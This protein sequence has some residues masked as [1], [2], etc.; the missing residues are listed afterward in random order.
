MKKKFLL[1]IFF[2]LLSGCTS[3]PGGGKIGAEK[4][5]ECN[6]SLLREMDE[7]STSI[8]MAKK[9][10]GVDEANAVVFLEDGKRHVDV[11]IKASN[12]QRLRL[13]AIRKEVYDALEKR[14]KDA[15]IHVT[16]DAKV[17]REIGALQKKGPPKTKEEA[18]KQDQDL[19]KIEKD[20][21]G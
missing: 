16:T 8:A 12:F 14:Y 18:C 6:V 17:Y 11:G 3:L 15:K 1:L 10:Y 20:M 19:K 21:K 4:K 5:P 9:A 7:E 13:K 2:L